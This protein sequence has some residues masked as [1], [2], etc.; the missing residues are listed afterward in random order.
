MVCL[1]RDIAAAG[2][3]IVFAI[4]VSGVTGLLQALQ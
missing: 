2:A 4:G 3:L 1:F